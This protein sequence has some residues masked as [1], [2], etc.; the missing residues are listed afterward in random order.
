MPSALAAVLLL[1]VS[2]GVALVYEVLWIRQFTNLF[3]A[4]APA[5]AA[6]LAALFFG[7]SLGSAVFGRFAGRIRRPLLAYGFLE[8]G[9]GAS[10][11]AVEPILEFL[12]F[13]FTAVPTA[14]TGSSFLPKILCAIIALFL[15]SFLMGGTLPVVSQ[16]FHQRQNHLGITGGALYAS[17]TLGATLGALSVPFFWLPNFGAHQS[18]NYG[19]GLSVIIGILGCLLGWKKPFSCQP[20]AT[21]PPLNRLPRSSITSTALFAAV[22]GLVLFILQLMWGRMFAQVH[23]NS[24]YSFSVVLAVFLFALSAGAWAARRL[25]QKQWEAQ[26]ILSLGWIAGGVITSFSPLI[27]FTLTGGLKYV[28]GPAGWSSYGI[29]LL[30]LSLPVVFLPASL[31]GMALPAIM[32][33]AGVRSDQPGGKTIGLLMACNAAGSIAGL[34]TGA[35]LL[36]QWLGLWLSTTASGAFLILLGAWIRLRNPSSPCVA[37]VLW[38][39]PAAAVALIAL[40]ISFSLP[41]TRISPDS[42]ERLISLAEGSHGIVAVIQAGTHRRIKLDNYYVLG[43]TSSTADE[44]M[45]GHLPL[46]LHP[47]PRQVA[48]LGIGTGITASAALFHPVEH[49]T[50]IEIIPE[51]AAAARTAFAQFNNSVLASSNVTVAI[52]DA[53]TLLQQSPAKFDVIIGDLV[54]PWRKGESA[55]Y[56]LEHFQT[57]RNALKP[58]GI[59]AQWLPLFQL[60]ETEFQLIATTFQIVFPQATV[61][62]GDFAPDRPALALIGHSDLQSLTPESIARNILRMRP[63]PANPHLVHPAGLWIYLAGALKMPSIPFSNLNSLDRPSLELSS[64]WSHAGSAAAQSQLFVGSK[65]AHYLD[66]LRVNPLNLSPDPLYWM[67]AGSLIHQSM[68]LLAAQAP[69]ASTQL[70]NAISRLPPEIQSAF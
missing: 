36:P 43:G 9:V 39:T 27:F 30:A 15:P 57:T 66:S 5:T 14:H 6:T 20:T 68:V 63:D 25:L 37:T 70:R 38:A 1:F 24:I 55:L 62:R 21:G 34:I 56:S 16:L 53:R 3:G 8:L 48:F 40:A 10:A 61:W 28:D 12:R 46:L 44:R 23:E 67:E 31:A 4:T 58:G 26:K 65:L 50:A 41:R 11:L 19:I 59:Y 33:L 18:Y 13:S 51:V 69:S 32:E 54:V 45:Q 49:A 42:D 22:S 47:N 35:F 2:G 7:L 17:N 60:S 64:P 29:Q 52:E